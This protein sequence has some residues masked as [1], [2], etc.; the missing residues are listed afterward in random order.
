MTI[1]IERF[2]I[3]LERSFEVGKNLAVVERAAEVGEL[4]H[5]LILH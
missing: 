3:K 4:R 2:L 5:D 1:A